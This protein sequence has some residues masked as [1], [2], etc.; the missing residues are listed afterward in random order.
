MTTQAAVSRYTALAAISG[1]DEKR[2]ISANAGLKPRGH[3][4]RRQAARRQRK[5][6]PREI[7]PMVPPRERY[8]LSLTP[9]S[10]LGCHVCSSPTLAW[11]WSRRRLRRRRLRRRRSRPAWRDPPMA[12][13]EAH[14]AKLYNGVAQHHPA[15]HYILFLWS[16]CLHDIGTAAFLL[17]KFSRIFVSARRIAAAPPSP[18]LFLYSSS[19]MFCFVSFWA[20]VGSRARQAETEAD[21]K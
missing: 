12:Y 1:D 11:R 16:I 18:S 14:K 9:G 19:S 10:S 7:G 13:F 2:V 4:C 5:F 15:P 8:P 3:R 17:N 6:P 20:R 21:K